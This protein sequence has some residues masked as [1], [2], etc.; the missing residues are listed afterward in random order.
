VPSVTAPPHPARSLSR[1]LVI[2]LLVG[3]GLLTAAPAR[4]QDDG[5][6]GLDPGRRVYDLTGSSLSAEQAARLT[7]QLDALRATGADAVVVVRALDADSDDTYDQVEALQQAWAA[8]T[9]TDQD[10]AVAI[11]VNRNPGDPTDAR[12]GIFVGRT[13]QDGNVPERE[14]RAIV[15][16]ALIPPIRGGDVD[17]G[18]RAAVD[19][20]GS[21]IRTGP[22]VSAFDRWSVEQ[23]N[24]W[25][26][27]TAIAVAVAG[28]AAAL[29]LFG[30]RSRFRG[31]APGPTTR[32]PGEL[33]P[34]VVEK[35]VTGGST[36]RS[37]QA[38]LLDLAARGAVAIEPEQ[39]SGEEPTVRIRLRDR[40]RVRDGI[41]E[42]VW[43]ELDE[44]AVDGVV[45]GAALRRLA[46]HATPV[47]AAVRQQLLDRGWLDTG[48]GP[49]RLGLAAVGVLALLAGGFAVVVAA[50]AG[51]PPPA[52]I[53]AIALV[54]VGLLACVFAAVHPP[55]SAA[56]LEAAA[57][58]KAYRDGLKEAAGDETTELDLDSALPDVVALGLESAMTRRLEAGAGEQ[59][60]LR[61][62]RSSGVG[63]GV[64]AFPWWAAFTSTTTSSSSSATSTVSGTGAGGGGGAAGST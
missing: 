60:S 20:L 8:T 37:R 15:E 64:A 56:G 3:L 36:A 55:L 28:L 10:V 53:G 46:D 48:S 50:S 54:A 19:R 5:V 34:A 63:D 24:S 43:A 16:D 45:D 57:P 14:Q 4:A 17:G 18:L 11:L 6:P 25:L 51:G 41:E 7:A 31:S 42:V 29:L 30:R 27:G 47:A 49:V 2:V 22:P 59:A 44:R 21:S 23:A 33:S 62:F 38:V 40:A 58:W 9:G 12:A 26:P 1:L 13:F 35:L 39:G 61:A 32:R 52:W